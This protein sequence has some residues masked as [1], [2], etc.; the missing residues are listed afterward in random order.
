MFHRKYRN[1]VDFYG[2]MRTLFLVVET[3]KQILE[4]RMEMNTVHLMMMRLPIKNA[5]VWHK[6]IWRS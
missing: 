2:D 5:S 4:R 3:E 6:N 1:L